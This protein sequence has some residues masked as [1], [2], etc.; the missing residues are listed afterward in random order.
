MNCW[1][2]NIDK[3][4]RDYLEDEIE[5]GRLRQGWGY[6]EDLNLKK[7]QKRIK[8]GEE[9]EKK[10]QRAWDRCKWMLTDIEPGDYI[11][12]KNIPDGD[13]FT[14]VKVNGQ[15]EFSI[16]EEQGDQGHILPI[17]KI[18]IFNKMNENVSAPLRNYINRERHP[19]R[20]TKKYKE[21]VISLAEMEIS[22]SKAMESEKFQESFE[23]FR[24]T[25]LPHVKEYL[26]NNIS[27]DIAE[28]LVFDILL[29]DANDESKL[30]YTAGP[31]EE[32][33]DM[34]VEYDLAGGFSSKIAIQVKMHWDEDNDTTGI[35]QLENALSKY[36]VEAG[37][38][39]SFA[40]QLGPDLEN[41]LKESKEEY[42][43]DIIYGE[44]LYMRLL[45]I[46]TNPG[47]EM[48][49]G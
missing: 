13:S 46:L 24:Q 16:D 34:I 39:V 28:K 26:K 25:L 23:A 12:V 8:K 3:D 29:N 21:E 17:E 45:E 30:N 40:D 19:I 49:L 31:D 11:L 44:D 7:I 33:A 2:W 43:I 36:D 9:L 10:V 38:L 20:R 32:G 41:R 5:N 18:R 42:M 1:I 14:I 22:Q 48:H 4:K 6:E 37:I 15:Y 35:E 27:S 47:F